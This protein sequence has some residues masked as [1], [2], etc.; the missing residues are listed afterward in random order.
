MV[1]AL[2]GGDNMSS[3]ASRTIYVGNLPGDVQEREIEDLF[4]KYGRIID[5]DLKVPPRPPGYCFIE[6]EHSRDADDAIWG[7]DGY[8]FDGHRLRVE[9]AHGGSRRGASVDHYSSYQSSSSGGKSRN[10]SRRSEYRVTISGL[11]SSAS[12][13]D[14]KDHMRRAGDVCFAQVFREHHGATGIVEYTNYDDMEYA[15]RKLDDSEFRNPY[16]RCYIRVREDKGYEYRRSLSRS[17][18]RSYSYSYSRSRSR[19]HSP[20]RSR[21]ISQRRSRS[22]TQSP[23]RSLSFKSRSSPASSRSYSRSPR[24]WLQERKQRAVTRSRSSTPSPDAHKKSQSRNS[25][26]VSDDD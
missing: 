22:R 5:I 8:S 11:P 14:L 18:R 12:W 7:R 4:Y 17:P 10:I 20:G 2:E 19:S 15:I 23:S 26:S 16:S 6:F 9:L 1:N 25:V 21:S 13:Q 24:H 3:R